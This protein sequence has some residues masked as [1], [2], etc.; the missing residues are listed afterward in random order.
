MWSRWAP[1]G[2]LRCRCGWH[3]SVPLR[4]HG[5][6]SGWGRGVVLES[7]AG[8]ARGGVPPLEGGEGVISSGPG[9]WLEVA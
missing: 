4:R 3:P 8:G 1:G 5:N 7:R 2:A 9:G 6:G